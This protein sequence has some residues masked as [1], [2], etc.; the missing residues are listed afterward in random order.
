[1]TVATNN[2][3]SDADADADATPSFRVH[4][5]SYGSMMNPVSRSRRGVI[6]YKE[7]AAILPNHSLV[8]NKGTGDVTPEEGKDVHG[9]LMEFHNKEDW[10][11]IVDCESGYDTNIAAVTTYYISEDGKQMPQEMIQAHYFQFPVGEGKAALPSERYLRILALGLEHHGVDPTYVEELKKHECLPSLKPENYYT[12]PKA[13]GGRPT[14]SLDEYNQRA[15]AEHLFLLHRTHVCQVK[16]FGTFTGWLTKKA[17]GK[18]C[19]GWA[20]YQQLYEPRLSQ[21]SEMSDL[22]DD[23]HAWCEHEL[24]HFAKQ[25]NCEFLHVMKLE[26]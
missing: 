20:L 25:T 6:S 17:I 11:Q 26:I 8:F 10:D 18:P 2:E 23:H 4:Y 1:M 21:C 15:E 9:V 5:F 24:C 22:T 13:E 16:S 19:T 7:Q 3:S 14:I 12:V